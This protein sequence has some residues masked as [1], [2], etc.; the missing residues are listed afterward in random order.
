MAALRWQLSESIKHSSRSYAQIRASHEHQMEGGKN[1]GTNAA[2]SSSIKADSSAYECLFSITLPTLARP[3]EL[4][5]SITDGKHPCA[6]RLRLFRPEGRPPQQRRHLPCL[7]VLS[8]R[9]KRGWCSGTHR[10]G[11]HIGAESTLSSPTLRP[12]QVALLSSSL[13][14]FIPDHNSATRF[15]ISHSG[16][17]KQ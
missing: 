16:G 13:L 11:R 15:I 5:P 2:K 8:S 6:L 17:P 4:C 14:L 10:G 9:G 1:I 3:F 12:L 7:D